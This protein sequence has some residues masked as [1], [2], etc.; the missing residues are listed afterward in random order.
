VLQFVAC[1]S[2]LQPGNLLVSFN[3]LRKR[4]PCTPCNFHLAQLVVAD[5]GVSRVLASTAGAGD[6][7]G[8]GMTATVT[9][10]GMTMQKGICGTEM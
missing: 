7:A 10:S 3:R 1:V 6:A 5:F 9:M 8:G 4:R 2:S